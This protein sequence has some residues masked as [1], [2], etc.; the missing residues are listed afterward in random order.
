MKLLF[1]E[2]FS[3]DLSAAVR[4]ERPQVAAESVH[5]RAFDGLL[6][7][8]LLEIL[9]AEKTVLVTR[10]VRTIP[11]ALAARLASGQTHGGV[12]FVPRSIRQTDDKELLRRLLALI[13]AQADVD[14]RCRVEWL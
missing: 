12:I 11:G 5:A 7:P 8:P 13:D 1:D 2:H 6:D 9:D 14:W 4:R 3:D 10:D